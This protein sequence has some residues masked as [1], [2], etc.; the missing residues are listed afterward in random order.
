[1]PGPLDVKPSWPRIALWHV[2]FCAMFLSG[3]ATTFGVRDVAH[4]GMSA[5]NALKLTDYPAN[6]QYTSIA[7]I[8]ITAYRA[9]LSQPTAD[10]V[11]EE[12]SKAVADRGGNAC[13]LRGQR[14]DDLWARRVFVTCEVL[15]VS[16]IRS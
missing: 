10:D 8:E 2:T 5:T 13:L 7:T 3:C 16:E 15:S 4:Q 12:V 1:M 14:P 9:G 11:W 6:R